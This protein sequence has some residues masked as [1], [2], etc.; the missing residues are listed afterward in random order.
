MSL[1]G[2]GDFLP[3]AAAATQLARQQQPCLGTAWVAGGS[4][5]HFRPGIT[6]HSCR[7]TDKQV[8]NVWRNKGYHTQP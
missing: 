1:A 3:A 5:T 6:Q 7:G 4:S 8:N 2:G